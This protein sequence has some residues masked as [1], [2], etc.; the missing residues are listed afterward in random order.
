MYINGAFET[1]IGKLTH[2]YGIYNTA[3]NIDGKTTP[4]IRVRVLMILYFKSLSGFLTQVPNLTKKLMSMRK[5]KR[6]AIVIKI[7]L[8][9][10]LH[11]VTRKMLRTIHIQNRWNPLQILSLS[12]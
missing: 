9:S 6:E 2:L 7:R 4:G 11:R 3:T 1:K 5:R 8:S 12:S 10:L